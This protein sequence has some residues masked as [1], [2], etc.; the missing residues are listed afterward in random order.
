MRICRQTRQPK[1]SQIL[2]QEERQMGSSN[3]TRCTRE[4][5]RRVL[6]LRSRKQLPPNFGRMASI[7]SSSSITSNGRR[8]SVNVI[9]TSFSAAYNGDIEMLKYCVENGCEVDEGT[10]AVAAEFGNLE[11][12]K[13]LRQKNCPWDK[14][15]SFSAAYNGDIE[16]MKYC[17]ENG[18]EV[19]ARTCANAAREGH[20]NVS[21]TYARRTV[22]GMNK[23]YD[24]LAQTTASTA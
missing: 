6:K 15:T 23:R 21:N 8:T 14:M 11:C 16:I 2:T 22:R 19:N 4:Q 18:C 1:M 12:L 20:L 13:Y 17:Y 9:K 5:P 24:S 3:G 10:C 7:T